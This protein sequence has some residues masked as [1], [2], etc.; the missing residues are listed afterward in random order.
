MNDQNNYRRFATVK[1]TVL[2]YPDIA[3]EAGLRWWIFNEK[4]N[5]FAHCVR[6]VGRKVLIDLD[7][8]ERW[9]DQGGQNNEA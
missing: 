5:G 4:E 2:K 9:I 8:F 3:T 7:A 1:N 6:R